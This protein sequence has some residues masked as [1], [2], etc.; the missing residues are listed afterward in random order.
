MCRKLALSKEEW[1]RKYESDCGEYFKFTATIQEKFISGGQNPTAYNTSSFNNINH[2]NNRTEDELATQNWRGL[3]KFDSCAYEIYNPFPNQ[4]LYLSIYRFTNATQLGLYYLKS[5]SNQ[6][7]ELTDTLLSQPHPLN[8]TETQGD[9]TLSKLL[10]KLQQVRLHRDSTKSTSASSL[11]SDKL[12][13][14]ESVS[15]TYPRLKWP[16]FFFFGLLST[17]PPTGTFHNVTDIVKQYKF[18]NV[19]KVVLTVLALGEEGS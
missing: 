19:E 13:S 6:T 11:R 16:D 5:D 14:M 10:S 7:I 17:R 18:V 4:T 12:V 15:I 3:A 2:F 9:W 8:A 1:R